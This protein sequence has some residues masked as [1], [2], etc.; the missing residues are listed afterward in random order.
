MQEPLDDLVTEV[1]QGRMSRRS[2]FEKALALGL[3][4]QAAFALLPDAPVAAATRSSGTGPTPDVRTRKWRRGRGWGWVWDDDDEVGSLNELSGELARKAMGLAGRGRVYDLGL[5]YDRRS[6]KFAG[7]SSGEIMTYRSPHGLRLQN[8]IPPGPNSVATAYASCHNS[9]S[10]N[11]ATQIDTLGH[12]YIG[13]DP[14]AYNGWKADDILGDYG[15]LKLGVE[16]IPPIVAP[17]TL[18]DVAGFLGEEALPAG[19]AIQPDLLERVLDAQGVDVDVLDVVL[20]RTGTGGVWLRGGGVGAD[21]A[22]MEAHDPAGI[23]VASARWLVEQKGALMVGSDTSGLE[24][25]PPVDRLP[26][27]TSFNPVH[28]YLLNQ[29][30]VHILELH[31][32]EDLAA[33]RTY[34]FAYVLGPPQIKGNTAG[35]AMRP[36]GIG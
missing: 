25:I 26:E 19:Y 9:M 23:S 10:D 27:G 8:D 18:I 22:A 13:D 29:Q 1:E 36:V 16:T 5:L 34:K 14:Y 31:N 15:L 11:V 33:D 17:A 6:F 30:G 24:V 4:T 32:C 21:I 20:V 2:F 28:V 7:H 12:I 35:T 3:S